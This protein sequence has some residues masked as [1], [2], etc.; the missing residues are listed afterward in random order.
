MHHAWLWNV[1][2]LHAG[3]GFFLFVCTLYV[4]TMLTF[5][6]GCNNMYMR[7]CNYLASSSAFTNVVRS[8]I[9]VVLYHKGR[10]PS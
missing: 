5:S 3:L 6:T 4:K 2:N 10:S 8:R 7:V 9:V 1:L